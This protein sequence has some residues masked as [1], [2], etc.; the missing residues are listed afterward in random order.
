MCI[1][2]RLWSAK[3]LET[4][5]GT[6]EVISK[7]ISKEIKKS[8]CSQWPGPSQRI[9]PRMGSSEANAAHACS[10]SETSGTRRGTAAEG[11]GANDASRVRGAEQAI[12]RLA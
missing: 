2:D 8:A 3:A 10:S 9:R 11:A 12:P 7:E 6:R 1:R 4:R 5:S